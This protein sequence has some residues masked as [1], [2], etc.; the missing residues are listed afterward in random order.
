[1]ATASITVDDRQVRDLLQRLGTKLADLTPCMRTIGEIVRD[2]V[3]ANFAEGRSPEG[4]AWKKSWRAMR[5]GGRTLIDTAILRNS[6][7]VQASRN[8]VRIG[9]PVK[10]GPVHQF[11]ARAGSFG[12]VAV[13]VRAHVRKARSG[14]SHSVR[15]HPRRQKLPWGDIPAR[16]F[17]GVRRDDWGEIRETVL[18][19]LVTRP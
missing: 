16:P 6:I 7:H 17:L 12:T 5:Q 9:T 1:M 14:K 11:G 19:Y 18:D 3:Q 8:E 10:Y 13:T 2:S 15:A 4:T